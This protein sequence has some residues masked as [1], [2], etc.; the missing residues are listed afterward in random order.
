MTWI[1][2]PQGVTIQDLTIDNNG[3]Q[4]TN[5]K[6]TINNSGVTIQ[7]IT[8]SGGTQSVN[9]SVALTSSGVR[10]EG[11]SSYIEINKN[12]SI[13]I[14]GTAV[15][16]MGRDFLTHHHSGVTSGLANTGNVV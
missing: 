15:T 8:T 13:V 14:Q 4:V 10:L 12:G 3:N 16:I 6:I 7:D 5:A 1:Y 11:G 9:T 2:G